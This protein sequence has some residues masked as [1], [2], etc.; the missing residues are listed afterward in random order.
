[1]KGFVPQFTSRSVCL[2]LRPY[3]ESVWAMEPGCVTARKP[4]REQVLP[5]ASVYLAIRLDDDPLRI[6][7]SIESE[8]SRSVAVSVVAGPRSQIFVMDVST[9][10]RAVGVEMWPGTASALLG[11]PTHE[12]TDTHIALEDLYSDAAARLRQQL[13]EAPDQARRLDLLESA[14]VK[15]LECA[16]SPHPLVRHAVRRLEAGVSVASLVRESGYSHRHFN[17]LFR[18]EVGLTPALYRR[19]FRLQSVLGQLDSGRRPSW[20]ELALDTGYADQAHFNREFRELSG[21]TPG[22]YLELAVAGSH[23]V[24]ILERADQVKFVQD[25]R[26]PRV[27]RARDGQHTQKGRLHGTSAKKAD[28]PRTH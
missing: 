25:G 9:P 23:H 2:A 3:V 4:G 24:P 27:L 21:M 16:V 7:P 14:L 15:R 13:Q 22:R 19:I 26:T 5:A 18:R 11:V 28:L 20:A 10:N 6:Y 1:M 8:R 12:L 17:A